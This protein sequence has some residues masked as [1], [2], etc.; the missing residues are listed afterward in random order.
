MMSGPR[1]TSWQPRSKRHKACW[2]WTQVCG[3]SLLSPATLLYP[4]VPCESKTHAYPDEPCAV[5]SVS[6]GVPI[7]RYNLG[8]WGCASDLKHRSPT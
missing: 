8:T 6:E 3:F 5:V 7:L 2:P 4:V 1:R